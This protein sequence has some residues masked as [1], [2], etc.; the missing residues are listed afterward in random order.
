MST[1]VP[2][3]GPTTDPGRARRWAQAWSPPAVVAAA[4]LGAFGLAVAVG[5]AVQPGYSHLREGISALAAVG[6]ASA[7]IMTA[8][9]LA[10]AVGTTAAGAA[11]WGRL[12]AGAAGRAGAAM[13][14]LSGLAM[15]VVAV[16]QQDCS[17]LVGACAA[18]EEAGT[19]S[20]HHVLH[21]LVSLAV[22][23]VLTLATFPLAR[24]L[25]RNG[26]PAG[27]AVAA[28]L[29]GLLGLVLTAAMVVGALGGAA[30]LG[31]RVFVLAI[32]GAP[33]LLAAVPLRR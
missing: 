26:G 10:L 29:A 8:G 11:L 7:S 23:V 1:T 22:F 20:G 5:G 4:G 9:F 32:F 31:Q 12:R 30:G 15:L 21:Q 14:V 33:V 25:R 13:V 28:R 2:T 6:A 16:N 19:L 3:T 18:A 17:D 24:G 27:A